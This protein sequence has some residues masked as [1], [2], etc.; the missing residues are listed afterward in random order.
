MHPILQK[1]PKIPYIDIHCLRFKLVFFYCI[2]QFLFKL[3]K[4]LWNE[5]LILY[6]C[7]KVS[8]EQK[9]KSQVFHKITVNGIRLYFHQFS[10]QNVA[11]T[12]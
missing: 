7:V 5:L 6:L 8:V 9:A 3:A 4:N 1:N 11:I 2:K 12:C 10:Y